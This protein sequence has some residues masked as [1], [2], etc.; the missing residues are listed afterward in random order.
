MATLAGMTSTRIAPIFGV[1]DVA[2]A[3]EFYAGLGFATRAYGG[4]AEYGFVTFD[5]IELH[6][7]GPPHERQLAPSSAYLFVAPTSWRQDGRPAAQTFDFPSTPR[8]AST[9]ACSSTSTAT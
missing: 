3:L 9:K 1:R 5:G 7:G 8:G 4:D 6:L 2:A